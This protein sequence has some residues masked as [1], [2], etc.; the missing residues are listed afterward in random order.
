MTTH[1]CEEGA[2]LFR[3]KVAIRKTLCRVK[4]FEAEGGQREWMRKQRSQAQRAEKCLG[5][6]AP[7][8]DKGPHQLFIGARIPAECRARC[9]N[10][11][12]EYGDCTVIEGVGQG[13]GGMNPLE[14]E[15]RECPRAVS[16]LNAGS[17]R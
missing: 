1:T 5:D 17:L 14:A 7:V 15:L 3:F 11:T 13:S 4:R 2:R 8:S 12:F 9:F 16:Q 6:G 10:R